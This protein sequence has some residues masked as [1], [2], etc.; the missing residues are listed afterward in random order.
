MFQYFFILFLWLSFTFKNLWSEKLL[1]TNSTF[2]NVTMSELF[3]N[4]WSIL[5][6]SPC[7]LEKNLYTFLENEEPFMC[8]TNLV[9]LTPVFLLIFHLVDLASSEQ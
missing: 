5:E 8:Q 2:I 9:L 6:N 7:A 1:C 4:I 3:P